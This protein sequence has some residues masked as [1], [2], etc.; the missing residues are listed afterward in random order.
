M[1]PRRSEKSPHRH[2]PRDNRP[3]SPRCRRR[4]LME[5]F[6]PGNTHEVT[7]QVPLFARY[8]L[9]T[10]DAALVA[11][12]EREG[13]GWHRAALERDG[14]TLSSPDVLA[15]GELANRHTPELMTH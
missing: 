2:G 3:R 11:A 12:V 4:H 1:P 9:F 14:A 15:L 5:T 10:S 8:N 13:A 7:N 6:G